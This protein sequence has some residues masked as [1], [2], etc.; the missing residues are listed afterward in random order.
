LAKENHEYRD[1]FLAILDEHFG[2]ENNPPDSISSERLRITPKKTER[3]DEL[4]KKVA[5]QIE[6]ASK[7]DGKEKE[8]KPPGKS[9]K[10]RS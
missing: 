4:E 6:P 1:R 5:K 10:K 3:K 8:T 9:P 7:K 2:I